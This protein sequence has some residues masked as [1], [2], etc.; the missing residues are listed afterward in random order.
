M[1]DV[2]IIGGGV[3]GLSA[4]LMLGRS[5]R[6]VCVLDAGRPRNAPAHRMH[7][8][9]TRDG[10]PP[11]E[12][13]RAA[14]ADLGRYPAITIRSEETTGLTPTRAGFEATVASGRPVAGRRVL[15]ATGLV[16]VLPPIPGMAEL[17]GSSVFHCPYC[18]GWETNGQ[19]VAVQGASP[20]RVRLAL[21]LTRFT[22]DVVL[23]TDGAELTA[24]DD[25]VLGRAGVGVRPER[26]VELGARGSR[27]TELRFSDG[28]TLPRDALFVASSTRQR[29]ALASGAG[30][31]L[32]PDGGIEVDEFGRTSVPGIYAAGDMAHRSTL[33]MPLA[34]VTAA[35]AAGQVAAAVLDQ[36]LLSDDFAL[37]APFPTATPR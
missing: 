24:P 21:Q 25:G 15:L 34:S 33:P 16:D 22:D 18:H 7:N 3:A 5:H 11:E 17:W 29:S 28:G 35:G 27:L 10:T 32:L 26:L 19:A 1:F 12:Y 14:L 30:C 6:D 20:Q 13:R 2:L 36:D 37:P 8:V 31:A 23:C 9:L 4:A